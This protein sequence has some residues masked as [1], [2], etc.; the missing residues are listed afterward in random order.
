VGVGVADDTVP[1]LT[2]AELAGRL[3]VSD[4]TIRNWRR[5]YRDWIAE[6]MG[7]DGVRRYPLARFELVAMLRSRNL[8]PAEIRAALNE[9]RDDLPTET[10]EDRMLALLEQIA[11]DVRRIADH[12]APRDD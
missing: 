7:A 6:R 12:L 3:G 9:Q 11:A 1:Y 5:A 2:I 8:P 4:S 10:A